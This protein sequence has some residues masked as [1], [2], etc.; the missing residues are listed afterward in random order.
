MQKNEYEAVHGFGF[1]L[2]ILIPHSVF[3]WRDGCGGANKFEPLPL[4]SKRLFN[5]KGTLCHAAAVE[6]FHRYLLYRISLR[7]AVARGP[8]VFT[9]F[10][11]WIHFFQGG[12]GG[13]DCHELYHS[14][15]E[16]PRID[17]LR[18]LL[19]KGKLWIVNHIRWGG[20]RVRPT[21]SVFIL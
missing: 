6:I 20:E 15:H 9:R 21:I 16:E 19:L 8:D 18:C 17:S 2:R 3:M 13:E 4:V 7:C 5:I 1:V 12:G 14:T 10:M 11:R